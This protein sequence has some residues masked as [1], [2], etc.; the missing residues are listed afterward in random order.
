MDLICEDSDCHVEWDIAVAASLLAGLAA[1][2][3]KLAA[4]HVDF[5]ASPK[6]NAGCQDNRDPL[7]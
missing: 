6:I 1:E 3:H 4:L 7:Q 2:F 5:F